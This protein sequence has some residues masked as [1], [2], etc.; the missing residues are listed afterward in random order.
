MATFLYTGLFG[1][2]YLALSYKVIALRIKHN[3]SLGDGGHK[4]LQT[5]SRVHGNFAEYVPLILILMILMEYAGA[6]LWI[7]HGLGVAAF[8][9][10]LLHLWGMTTGSGVNWQRQG[11]MILT[12]I[13]IFAGSVL[14]ILAFINI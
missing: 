8:A 12:Y 3:V 1:L 4:D 9:G 10:R 13:V 6:A 11:G 5:M 7:V 2:F 14:S